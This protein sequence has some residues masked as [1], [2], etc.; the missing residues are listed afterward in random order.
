[1]PTKA[2]QL[3][4]MLGVNP[5]RRR[6]EDCEVGKGGARSAPAAGKAHLWPAVVVPEAVVQ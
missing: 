4:D 2:A 5:S 6:W 1:M 3:L